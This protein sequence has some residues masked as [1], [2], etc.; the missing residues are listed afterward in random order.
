MRCVLWVERV[1]LN[2]CDFFFFLAEGPEEDDYEEEEEDESEKEESKGA[3]LPMD[4]V[5]EKLYFRQIL[6]AALQREPAHFQQAISTLPENVKE[7]L[8]TQFRFV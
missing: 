4:D 3:A 6:E 8:R 2:I 5:N 7:I 1:S